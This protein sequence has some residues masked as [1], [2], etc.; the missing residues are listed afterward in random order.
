MEG[1]QY[2]QLP[3]GT[4][5]CNHS[6][7][8]GNSFSASHSVQQLQYCT[9]TNSVQSLSYTQEAN[10][11]ASSGFVSSPPLPC[12]TIS[13]QVPVCPTRN[14]TGDVMPLAEAITQLSFLEF[15]QHCGVSIAPPQP[16]QLP[17]PISLLDAAVQAT[18][19]CDAFQD[20]STQTSD[21]QVSSLSFDVAVQTSPH[22]IHISSWMLPYRRPHKVLRLSTSLHRWVLAQFP[23]FLLIFLFR[24][25]YAVWCYTMLPHNYRSRSSLL[26]VFS[27]TIL[28]TAKTLFVSP[29][30]Q[31]KVHVPCCSHRQDSNSSPRLLVPLLV[32]TCTLHMAHL[33][34]LHLYELGYVQLFQLRL[35]SPLLVPPMW[36]HSIYVQ[37]LQAREV[38]VPPWWERTILLIQMLVQGLFLF[39]NRV[40]SFFLWSTLVNP[41]LK[42]TLVLILL[43]AISCIT[44]SAF[45]SS[46]EPRP[47]A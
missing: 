42:G 17:V 44:N 33:L 19:P 1:Q 38:P 15:L 24:L 25:P 39:L 37:P 45:P 43:T 34:Q 47:G 31:Y 13:S 30:H 23:R 32:L 7:D 2:V 20:V 46:M 3:P 40:L 11:V 14:V 12:S 27:R 41:N 22:G 16:S 8:A 21:Q 18:P 4:T 28:W 6:Y 36:D 29:R 26:A 10:G 5:E 35:H 9:I